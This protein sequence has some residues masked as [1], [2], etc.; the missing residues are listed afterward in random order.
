MGIP[1]SFDGFPSVLIYR[2]INFVLFGQIYFI[3]NHHDLC[4][5][6]TI[7]DGLLEPW[8][9]FVVQGW[10]RHIV[11]ENDNVGVYN[12]NF[13]VYFCSESERWLCIVT[14]LHCPIAGTWL[15]A[16]LPLDRKNK[17]HNQQSILYSPK[18]DFRSTSLSKTFFL[19]YL[20]PQNI[21]SHT[22]LF[23]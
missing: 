1:L 3:A 5:L 19:S 11:Y 16:C 20:T 21:P 9:Y 12:S 17:N 6:W 2:T 8:W 13:R 18:T 7:T 4:I 23:L 22:C 10:V 14:A 15:E